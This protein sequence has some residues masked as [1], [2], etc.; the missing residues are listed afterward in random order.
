MSALA[1]E[2]E[3]INLSQGFPN[4]PVSEELIAL[5]SKYMR[6]GMNQYAPAIGIPELRHVLAKK[7]QN[8]YSHTVDVD[9]EITITAGATEAL[10]SSI[11]AL[12]KE[13]DEVMIFEPAYDSYVPAIRLSGGIPIS[14]QLKGS[15]Y[16][17]NW[18]E[19]KRKLSFKT[20]MIVINTP[21]NPCGTI[22]DD[23]DIRQLKIITE[24][25]DILILSDE[26]YEHI[27]FDD[28]KH[29]SLLS[30]EL[31]NRSIC[32]YSFGKVLHNTGWKMGYVVAPPFLTQE[33]RKVHEFNVFSVN[34]PMQYAIAEFYENPAN[35]LEVS[36]FYQEKRD[37]FL[38]LMKE[39][40]FTFI[41]TNGS[42]FQLMEYK[43]ITDQVDVD[44]AKK[45]TIENGVAS[46]P[47]SVFYNTK[48][49]EKMLRFC[50]AK[51]NDLLQK[52]AEELCKI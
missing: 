51:T 13:G 34:T 32:V 29:L 48:T 18:E 15:N 16:K 30:T 39:S 3:A 33:I 31:Y 38:S 40:R 26:V 4:F 19:V 42:Y 47:I 52:A 8:L 44:F 45:L 11:T 49:E 25:N 28:K 2:H 10:F 50:F 20:R 35:Y 37:Y 1:R 22:L 5:V 12:V 9:Q 21:H 41:P 24:G 46:I 7:I 36:P 43:D 6:Q 27:V 14:V 17:I 23:E